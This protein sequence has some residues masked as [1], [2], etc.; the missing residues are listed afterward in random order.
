VKVIKILLLT[1]LTII[2]LKASVQNIKVSYT[3]VQTAGDSYV[4]DTTNQIYSINTNLIGIN[5]TI[6][7]IDQYG[8]NSIE[9][10]NGLTISSSIIVSNELILNLSNGAIVNIRRANTFSFD[11]GANR[12]IGLKG[13]K[14]DFNTFVTNTLGLVSVPLTG[15]APVYGSEV[16]IP[17][18]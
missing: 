6:T 1:L 16:K 4:G 18:Y 12:A 9:L 10:I 13:I 5:N 3:I 15:D 7:I 14:E 11:V 2:S 17:N 8:D